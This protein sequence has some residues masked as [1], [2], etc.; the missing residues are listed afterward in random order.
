MASVCG[1]RK[2]QPENRL[3]KNNLTCQTG[4]RELRDGDLPQKVIH[5]PIEAYRVR[6]K[7]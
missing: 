4:V 2:Q 1:N 5:C 6:E 7:A 3:K